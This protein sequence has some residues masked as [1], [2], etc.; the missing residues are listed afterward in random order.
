M[1]SRE[2]QGTAVL[3]SETELPAASPPSR[4]EMGHLSAVFKVALCLQDNVA[5]GNGADT[6]G[7]LP[8]SEEAALVAEVVGCRHWSVLL[9]LLRL[10]MVLFPFPAAQPPRRLVTASLSGFPPPSPN[11]KPEQVGGCPMESLLAQCA[12]CQRRAA[13]WGCCPFI[14]GQ[15]LEKPGPH[16]NAAPSKWTDR[17]GFGV[18]TVIKKGLSV[19]RGPEEKSWLRQ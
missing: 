15:G 7:N 5:E 11:A 13:L 16:S 8:V 3:P 2:G 1:L 4:P 19:F 9:E 6:T 12:D 10:G 17:Q 18:S 14:R